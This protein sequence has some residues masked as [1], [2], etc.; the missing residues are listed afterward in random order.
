MPLRRPRQGSGP[1]RSTASLQLSYSVLEPVGVKGTADL[2]QWVVG[3]WSSCKRLGWRGRHCWLLMVCAQQRRMRT[4]SRVNRGEVPAKPVTSNMHNRDANLHQPRRSPPVHRSCPRVRLCWRAGCR[5]RR[6]V[7]G[8]V[9][10]I[11]HE[12]AAA[13]RL[14]GSGYHSEQSYGARP[15]HAG[16]IR[17][18]W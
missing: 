16:G 5:E 14:S 1:Y 4:R 15:Q 8:A 18:C 9:H 12:A 10:R 2:Q 13:G 7:A 11:W 6:G 3:G 17:L